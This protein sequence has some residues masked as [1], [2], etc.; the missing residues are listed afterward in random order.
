MSDNMIFIPSSMATQPKRAQFG[1]SNM[2]D[3]ENY[4]QLKPS[5]INKS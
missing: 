1:H 5:K 3:F 4:R 2:D